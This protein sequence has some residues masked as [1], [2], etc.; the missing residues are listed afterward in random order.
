MKKLNRRVLIYGLMVLLT[1]LVLASWPY[2]AQVHIQAHQVQAVAASQVAIVG[3]YLHIDNQSLDIQA[4]PAL[5]ID[6]DCGDLIPDIMAIPE[7]RRP[8]IIVSAH[9]QPDF[10]PAELSFYWCPQTGNRSPALI[11]Y[12]QKLI[13]YMYSAVEPE[14]YKIRYPM[15]VGESQMT[16]RLTDGGGQNAARAAQQIS[17]TQLVPGET[18]SF[19]DYVIPSRA[20]GYVEGL[21]LFNTDEGPRWKPD[22]GGGICRTS[23]VLNFA[24]EQAGLE[25]LERHH[26]T[27]PVSYARSGEDTA[28]ARSAGWDYKF[29]NSSDKTIKIVAVQNGDQLGFRIYELLEPTETAA[30]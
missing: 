18:F 11:W 30:D 22:L 5:F 1:G 25:V 9:T 19:Y 23:T 27:E 24:V 3:P 6:A 12:D 2:R 13:G 16:N 26:H 28:V 17:G 4:R 14:L 7:E 20:N 8:Y 21:T 29:C 15:Q 10:L